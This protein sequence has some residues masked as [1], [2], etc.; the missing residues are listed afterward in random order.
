MKLNQVETATPTL[1]KLLEVHGELFESGVGT[2]NGYAHLEIKKGATPR[3]FKPRSVPYA[4][5]DAIEKEL[6]RLEGNGVLE[7]VNSSRFAAPIVPVPKGDGSVRICG[8]YKVTV[9][10]ELYVDQYPLP[11]PDDIF[12]TLAAGKKFL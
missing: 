2:L 9:N 6:D 8:V 10:L 5:R 4:L 3:F 12:A 1:E 11:K 7:R